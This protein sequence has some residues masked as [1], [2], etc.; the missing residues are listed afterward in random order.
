METIAPISTV[1][2]GTRNGKDELLWST[3]NASSFNYL[4]HARLKFDGWKVENVPVDEVLNPQQRGSSVRRYKRNNPYVLCY[5]RESHL[6]EVLCH[7]TE[8]DI[9]THIRN[10]NA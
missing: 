2:P 8:E 5:I 10:I 4:N 6:N 7:I 1:S 3:L 9:P